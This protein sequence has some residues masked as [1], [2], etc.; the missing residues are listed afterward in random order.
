MV[1]EG[2]RVNV[3]SSDGSG[4]EAVSFVQRVVETRLCGVCKEKLRWRRERERDNKG[5]KEQ[6]GGSVH[7]LPSWG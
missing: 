6:L 2:P 5:Y 7:D 3:C 4:L 1:D